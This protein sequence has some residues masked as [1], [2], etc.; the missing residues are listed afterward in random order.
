MSN[1]DLLPGLLCE[2]AFTVPLQ[3]CVCPEQGQ[4][5]RVITHRALWFA[6]SQEVCTWCWGWELESCTCNKY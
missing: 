4:A 2:S 1:E 3:T 5:P 6:P